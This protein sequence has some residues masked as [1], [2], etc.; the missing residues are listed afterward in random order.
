MI[1]EAWIEKRIAKRRSELLYGEL[2]RH[3]LREFARQGVK[4]SLHQQKRLRQWLVSGCKTKISFKKLGSVEVKLGISPR[5]MRRILGKSRAKYR[6]A[7][8]IEVAAAIK[9]MT[10]ILFR[11]FR[12]IWPTQSAFEINQEAEFCRRLWKLWK[13]PLDGLEMLVSLS[14]GLGDDINEQAREKSSRAR[15][16]RVDVLTRLHGK[17]CQTARE[18]STL[19]RAGYADGA[20]AR[21]RSLHEISVTMLF[22]SERGSDVLYRYINHQSVD[23]W[24][25][26]VEHEANAEQMNY[27]KLTKDELGELKER[28]DSMVSRYGEPFGTDYGWAAKALNNKKPTFRDI[29]KAVSLSHWRTEYKRASLNVHAGVRGAFVRLGSL[30]NGL[31]LAG[32]SNVGLDTPGTNTAISLMQANAVLLKLE[33]ELDRIITMHAMAQLVEQIGLQFQKVAEGFDT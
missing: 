18:I 15:F 33:P 25:S 13:K 28:R 8:K 1:S 3:A 11:N 27:P 16:S 24:R 12:R 14:A 23:A 2:E 10:P 22:L 29:E 20:I 4:L 17:A 6:V 7:Y 21:W 19:L 9:K 5:Q 32:A 26:A 30:D 31:V